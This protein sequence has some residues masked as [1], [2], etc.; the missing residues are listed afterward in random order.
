LSRFSIEKSPDFRHNPDQFG[1]KTP[2]IFPVFFG[3]KQLKI[4]T[5]RTKKTIPGGMVFRLKVIVV[6]LLFN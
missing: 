4:L 5:H 3:K 2:S 1:V 6:V